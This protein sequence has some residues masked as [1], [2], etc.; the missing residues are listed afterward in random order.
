MASEESAP[1]DLL[2]D[3]VERV[4]ERS[5]RVAGN[6][7]WADRVVAIMPPNELWE[8]V[9]FSNRTGP[10]RVFC[11][12]ENPSMRPSWAND[13]I[14]TLHHQIKNAESLEHFL[15]WSSVHHT[16]RGPQN[17]R[18]EEVSLPEVMWVIE[19]VNDSWRFQASSYLPYCDRQEFLSPEFKAGLDLYR[20]C[21]LQGALGI[22]LSE[23]RRYIDYKKTHGKPLD[24]AFVTCGFNSTVLQGAGTSKVLTAAEKLAKQKANKYILPDGREPNR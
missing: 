19:N 2:R 3:M 18:L 4:A 12:Y 1:D 9:L 8:M 11:N 24:S 7:P 17:Y 22:N 5:Y 15:E 14:N 6:L 20:D 16:E 10:V 13:S 21:L 23:V